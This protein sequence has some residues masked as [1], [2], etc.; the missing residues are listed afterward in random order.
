MKLIKKGKLQILDFNGNQTFYVQFMNGEIPLHSNLI[1][2]L[3]YN[4]LEKIE[5]KVLKWE[6]SIWNHSA[7]ML[8]DKYRVIDLLN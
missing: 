4:E 8:K 6:I 5:G 2:K 7:S 3:G 1:D